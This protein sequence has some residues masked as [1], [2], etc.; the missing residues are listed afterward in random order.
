[1]TDTEC[2][3][4]GTAAFGEMVHRHQDRLYKSVYR[5]VDC[6]EDAQDVV[7]E[8]F[9]NAYQSLV[10]FKGDSLFFT[11]LNRIAVNAALSLLR[12]RTPMVSIDGREGGAGIDPPDES[13]AIRP[14]YGL[15]RAEE[16]RRVQGALGRLSQEQRAVLIMK[17]VEGMRYVDIAHLLAVPT[18]TIRSRLHRARLELRA[19]LQPIQTE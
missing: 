3:R 8:A 1:M 17:D 12:S 6:A 4:G 19:L 14:G 16:G 11:W 5:L 15:E 10:S 9:L 13:E 2:L 7:Q 18:G